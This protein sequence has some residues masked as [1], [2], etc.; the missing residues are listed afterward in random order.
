MAVAQAGAG[1]SERMRAA[2]MR[3]ERMY[4]IIELA[5]ADGVRGSSA[6]ARTASAGDGRAEIGQQ[7]FAASQP[8][9]FAAHAFVSCESHQAI[10]NWPGVGGL[11]VVSHTLA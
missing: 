3:W 5:S 4:A 8:Y 1:R 9:G 10:S 7:P 11:T 6:R 2:R